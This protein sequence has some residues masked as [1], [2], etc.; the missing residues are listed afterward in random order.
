MERRTCQYFLEC[1]FSGV[2]PLCVCFRPEFAADFIKG[3]ISGAQCTTGGNYTLGSNFL[4]VLWRNY[5]DY[6]H[7]SLLVCCLHIVWLPSSVGDYIFSAFLCISMFFYAM[8]QLNRRPGMPF[9]LILFP[10]SH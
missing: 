2:V 5:I 3:G 6:S 9:I 7:I 4:Q 10:I 8:R 1:L